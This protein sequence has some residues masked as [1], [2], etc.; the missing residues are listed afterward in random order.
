MYDM[1]CFSTNGFYP[2]TSSCSSNT[3]S[4]DSLKHQRLLITTT[5]SPPPNVSHPYF[6][7]TQQYIF[8]PHHFHF[9]NNN[10]NNNNTE[11]STTSNIPRLPSVSRRLSLTIPVMTAINTDDETTKQTI[12]S[13]PTR[14]IPIRLPSTTTVA[15]IPTNSSRISSAILRS[16]PISNI[17]VEM[18]IIYITIIFLAI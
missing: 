14:Q 7:Q 8:D 2:T 6:Q 16:A 1:G 11:E 12:P 4:P 9:T 15:S 18:G 13:S 10:T 17:L 5:P 3:S